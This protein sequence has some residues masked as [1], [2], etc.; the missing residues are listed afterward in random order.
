MAE[1]LVGCCGWAEARERYFRDFRAVEIQQSFYEPPRVELAERWRAGAPPRFIFTMKAWQA[2]THAASSPT[3]RRMKTPIDPARRDCYGGFQPTPE[4]REA[5]QRTAAIA[6]ALDAAVIVFQCPA[7]FTPSAENIANLERFFEEIE[8]G[9]WMLAWEP[10]GDWPENIIRGLCQRLELLH[11]VDPFNTEPVAG[12]AAYFRLH[13]RGGYR[14]RHSDEDLGRLLVMCRRQIDAGRAPVY[15]MFNNVY[16][17][18]D[19]RR[20]WETAGLT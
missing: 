14:Y 17:R 12:S 9:P 7:R 20:F 10:R 19:A 4:V 1:I 8:R 16:M 11:C 5:W 15:V 2:I 6:R 18:E 13:G 3:Y